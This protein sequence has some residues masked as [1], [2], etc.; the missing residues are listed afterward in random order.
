MQRSLKIA[1]ECMGSQVHLFV[2][3]LNKYLY[4]F[5]RGC[6]SIATKYFKVRY[7]QPLASLDVP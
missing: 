6:P 2:E 4:F 5:E 1:N 3:I 7:H